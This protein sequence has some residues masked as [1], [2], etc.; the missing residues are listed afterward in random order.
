MKR[1]PVIGIT[2]RVCPFT[3][4]GRSHD[5]Y[6]VAISYC[7]AVEAAGGTPIILPLT[8]EASTIESWWRLMDGLMLPGGQDIAP[9]H[10]GEEPRPE[11]ET[12]DPRRD[13]VELVL[14]R[15]AMAMGFPLLAICR[16]A[17]LLNVAAGG[18]LHQDIHAC[19]GRHCMRHFQKTMEET[20]WH[21]VNTVEGSLLEQVMGEHNPAVNSYHHQ[22]VARLAEGFKVVAVAPDGIVEAIEHTSH[23]FALGVQWHPELLWREH[24]AHHA[25]FRAHVEAAR[26]A[27]AASNA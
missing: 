2:S 20:T 22:S 17:Q 3:H 25:L 6:G 21:R 1:R 11:L 23:P 9:Q 24:A 5:R 19:V 14:A 15:R 13:R 8:E 12:V 7:E 27:I 26:R 10:Y 4:D 18:S 16:G